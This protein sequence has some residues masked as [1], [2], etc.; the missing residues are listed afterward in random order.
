MLEIS[1]ACIDLITTLQPGLVI[2]SGAYLSLHIN[3]RGKIA[4]AKFN[5]ESYYRLQ[6]Y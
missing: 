5:L 3:C 1:S 2:D 6:Y 4:I